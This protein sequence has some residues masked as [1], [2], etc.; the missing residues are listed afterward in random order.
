LDRESD[1]TYWHAF[2]ALS[3]IAF[4]FGTYRDPMD[5]TETYMAQVGSERGPLLSVECG[6][7]T[8]GKMM[9]RVLAGRRLYS[10]GQF[11]GL[12]AYQDRVRFDQR[13]AATFGFHYIKEEAFLKG[14]D[15][16][17]FI[18]EVRASQSVTIEF[19]SYASGQFT[20]TLPLV[21]AAESIEKVEAKCFAKR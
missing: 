11:P 5:D 4:G 17:R 20:V 21:N 13:P 14:R 3:Q 18:S 1:V 6:A 9:V 10:S 2:A 16:T 15:A 7:L 12:A 8:D 19:T